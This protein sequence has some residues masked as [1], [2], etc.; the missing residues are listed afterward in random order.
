MRLIILFLIPNFLLS[1]NIS[2]TVKEYSTKKPIPSVLIISLGREVTKTDANGMATFSNQLKNIKLV[3]SGFDTTELTL[4]SMN[5]TVYLSRMEKKLK[6][7]Q[8]KPIE[9]SFANHL[10]QKMIQAYE[11][12]HP[13]NSPNYKFFIYSKIVIDAIEDSMKKG[14]TSIDS[15]LNSY[16]KR[17]KFFVWEK[18]TEAKHDI[19]YG[20]KKTI[21]NSNMSGLKQPIYEL[22]A[23][24]LDKVNYLPWMFRDKRYKE[25][26]FRYEGPGKIAGRKVYEINFF[27]KRKYKSKQSRS[28]F[29]YID[30][31]TNALLKYYG[32]TQEGFGEIENELINNYCFNKYI[33]R[34][35][36]Q[37]SIAV[38]QTNPVFEYISRIKN[39]TT[40]NEFSK[41]EFKG[42]END[43]SISLNDKS[44]FE[45]LKTMREGDTMD[46]RESNTF[47]VLDSLV[48]KYSVYNKIRLVL[49]LTKGFI[50]FGKLNLSINDIAQLNRYEGFRLQLGGETNYEFSKKLYLNGYTAYGFKDGELKIGAGIKYLASYYNQAQFTLQY[51]RDVFPIGR[52]QQRFENPIDRINYLTHLMYFGNYYKDQ[53]VTLGFQNDI[54]KHITQKT[55]AQFAEVSSTSPYQFQN[56]NL[57][58]FSLL[59]TGMNLH[60]YP[61]SNFMTSSEGK[62]SIDKRPTQFKL[63]YTLHYPLSQAIQPYHT[64]DFEVKSSIYTLLG[65]SQIISLSGVSSSNTP[66]YNLYEG[67]GA[68]PSN[69]DI[70]SSF[71]FSSHRNFVTMQ[72]ST[73]HSN[74]FTS[75]FFSHRLPRIGLNKEKKI[76]TTLNYRAILGGLTDPST[77][78]LFLLA[79]TKLY[80]EAGVEFNNLFL[81]LGVGVYYRLG[82]YQLDGVQ[83][84]LAGRL[85]VKF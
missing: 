6:E 64:A 48:K 83:N 39:V 27:P 18:L 23:L 32:N 34:K 12:M 78:N 73:F 85:V 10:V 75:V 41:S 25:Y 3:H 61:K 21:L 68:S 13:D 81:V 31:S 82:A 79:P 30:S 36:S 70:L 2:I 66:V 43:I 47:V 28:G 15:E 24:S 8:I 33:Y 40:N 52:S 74:Y 9:D 20:E 46:Y 16:L 44:S 76:S 38:N 17:S 57:T 4:G 49:A 14:G 19:R 45:Q 22:L 65:G 42:N 59:R 26:I 71:G 80:Q 5:Q 53:S 58:T 1:Q 56:N 55:W 84:N 37:K 7:V 62:F 29:I 77:H 63:N 72:P 69:Y 50:K 11:K 60:W 67:L 35:S 51:H 54:H